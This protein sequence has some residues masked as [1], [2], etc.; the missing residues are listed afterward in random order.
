MWGTLQNSSHPLS[1]TDLRISISHELLREVKF[2]V[3]SGVTDGQ[4]VEQ[5]LGKSLVD[6]GNSNILT[7][8][9]GH[10]TRVW[11]GYRFHQLLNHQ[12]DMSTSSIIYCMSFGLHLNPKG[13]CTKIIK[14][15]VTQRSSVT[16]YFICL[17]LALPDSLC[18][19]L[20]AYNQL[21]IL[22]PT[23]GVQKHFGKFFSQG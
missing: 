7:G 17:A 16:S 4:W 11:A 12:F 5:S 20:T 8:A 21:I 9:F 3:T 6:R 19:I 23:T 22:A 15:K 14:C 13:I 10:C 1:W 18:Q 2:T